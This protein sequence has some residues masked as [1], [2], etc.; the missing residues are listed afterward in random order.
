[1]LILVLSFL[2]LRPFF[3][4]SFNPNSI[5]VNYLEASRINE[6]EY[7][8]TIT[9]FKNGGHI[10]L[11]CTVEVKVRVQESNISTAEQY[12]SMS[13]SLVEEETIDCDNF[14]L[15][16]IDADQ[17]DYVS[18]GDYFRIITT[19]EVELIITIYDN[20]GKSICGGGLD[21]SQWNQVA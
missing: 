3:F 8:L 5:P 15:T 18:E 14:T 21:T 9:N 7:R 10:I 19:K 16:F 6:T 11:E 13:Y 12:D 1:M 17:D 4:S 2:L 20:S